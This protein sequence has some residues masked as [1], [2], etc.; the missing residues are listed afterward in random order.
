VSDVS[1]RLASAMADRYRIEQEIG[2]GGMANVY[3]AHDLRHDRDVAIKV[4]R[5]ALAA[6]VGRERFLAEIRTTAA[7]S[8][9]H[10]LPLYDSGDAQGT[11]YY[12]MPYIDGESLRNRLDRE[13]PFPVDEALHIVR[14]VAD[15]LAF[16]HE[17]R[18]IH[19]DIKP[20]NILLSHGHAY[21]ADFGIARAL[22]AARGPRLTESG[23]SIGTPAYMSPEQAVGDDVDERTDQYSLGCVAYEMI[24]GAPPFDGPTPQ[25]ILAHCLT[26]TPAP[27]S[28]RRSGVP[29]SVDRAI[30]RALARAAEDRFPT[31]RQFVDALELDASPSPVVTKSVAVLPFTSMS[32]ASDDDFFADGMTEEIINALTQLPGLRVAARTSCFAFK[33]KNEDLRVVCDRLGVATVL[34]GSVRKAGS[35]LRVTAQ[36]I[37]GTDGWHLWSERYDRELVDVFAIQDEIARAIARKLRLALLAEPTN[38]PRSA[39]SNF[40]AYELLLKGRALQLRRGPVLLESLACFKRAVELEPGLAEAHALLADTY[41]LLALYGIAPATEM[42]PL[43]RS[44]VERALALDPNQVEAL[45]CLAMIVALHDWDLPAS[46]LITDRALARDPSH[47]RALCER[48]ICLACTRLT[49]AQEERAFADLTTAMQIDPL[50]GWAVAIHAFCL[51]LVG[52]RDEAIAEA[53]RAADLDPENFT[54]RWVMVEALAAANRLDEALAAMEPALRMSGRHPQILAALAAIHASRGNVAA[55]DAVHEELQSRAKTGYISWA[56]QAAVAA[57]AGHLDEARALLS[58]AVEGR[59]AF[60]VIWK[61]GTWQALCSDAEGLRIMQTTGLMHGIGGG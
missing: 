34:E 12:V 2:A 17:R 59:D 43:A 25:A 26:G 53:S 56:V 16:A 50:N 11:L 46:M 23:T 33:G 45:A 36:L 27:L 47:V 14:E 8:H 29:A 3:L 4:L 28:A 42:I 15:A 31:M 7:L 39:P 55:A 48:A 24:A 61:L 57:S 32:A 38:E 10:I 54:A 41:R 19:R 44:A 22:K 35:R 20:E 9:A 51:V 37:N 60:L 21:V 18:V 49:P 58:R 13:K 40:K 30:H 52:R 6:V 5:P 1:S